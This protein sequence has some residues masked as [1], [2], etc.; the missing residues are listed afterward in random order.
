MPADEP[1]L[2]S[3]TVVARLADL[4]EGVYDGWDPEGLA[5][6]LKPHG[7]VTIQ[8]GRRVNGKVVNRRGIDC[9]HITAAIAERDGNRDAG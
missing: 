2:W 4:R 1:K 5:A 3:E 6:A 9:S 7:V 8:V